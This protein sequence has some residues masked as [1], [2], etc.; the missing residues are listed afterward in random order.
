MAKQMS[1]KVMKLTQ[2]LAL[3]LKLNLMTYNF[4]QNS[5]FQ[6]NYFKKHEEITSHVQM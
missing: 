3:K 4:H 5:T 6:G 1:K 2:N